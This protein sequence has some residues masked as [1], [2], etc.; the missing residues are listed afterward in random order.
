[1]SDFKSNIVGSIQRVSISLG[2]FNGIIRQ[3]QSA[4]S[5]QWF[6]QQKK[7]KKQFPTYTS[8]VVGKYGRLLTIIA[9]LNHLSISA[10]RGQTPKKHRADLYY[11]ID[12]YI[13]IL[14]TCTAHTPKRCIHIPRLDDRIMKC[15]SSAI[16]IFAHIF[17]L[18]QN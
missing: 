2:K 9:N 3:Y 11:Y 1:M 5:I 14:W 18:S 10:E 15:E 17:F 4:K 8:Q 6:Q 16:I 13:Y 7:K 12:P